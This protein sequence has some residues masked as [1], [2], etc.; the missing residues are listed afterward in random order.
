TNGGK[1]APEC[2]ALLIWQEGGEFKHT[3]HVAVITEVLADKVRIAEQNVIHSRLPSGQQWTRELPMTV[4]AGR[5][6]LQDTFDDTEI[7]GWMIQKDNEEFS[8]PQPMPAPEK[9]TIHAEHIENQGQ[10]AAN[11]LNEDNPLEAAY[12]K[13]MKGHIVNHGD[14]YRYFALSESAQ[15]ELIRA[16]NELHLM[17]LHATDKVL[18][19]DKLLQYF[20]IPKLL[21]PRLRLS[22]QN[23]RYQTITGR[24][25]FCLDERGLKVYEYN[26]DS[27]SCH[28]EAGAILPHWA[29]L[30]GL[31]LRHDPGEGLRNA[32]ADTWK[33]SHATPLVHIMQDHDAEEE[34]HA[35]FMRD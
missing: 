22:W 9:L 1:R 5:Y 10:F 24:M 16:T 6:R 18:K 3:G 29:A 12:V 23:R 28:A 30:A 21:W 20:N 11:W 25:D 7:L 19:D 15:H 35:L 34:Y 14:Q 32:L 26:T 13:A 31:T 2:G 8:L 4:T 17:Y 27:A 33:H